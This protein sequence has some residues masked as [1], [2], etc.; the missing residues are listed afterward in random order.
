MLAPRLTLIALALIAVP[1]AALAE[2]PILVLEFSGEPPATAA[3]LTTSMAEAVRASGSEVNEASREDVVTLAGCAEASDDCLRQA[4]GMLEV[5]AAVTGEVHASG[6]GVSV[7]L[8]AISAEGEPRT[9]T[10]VLSG[11]SPDEQARQ[12]RPQ[13]EAFWKNEPAPAE[14]AP[15]PAAPAEPAAGADLSKGTGA[16]FSASRVEPYAWAIAGT[17]AGLIAVGS[18]L[19]VA[20]QNKQ[21]E[22]DDAPTDTVEDL[23]HLADLESSGRR[24]ARWGNV[25]VLVGGAAA[26]AGGFLIYRQGRAS[27]EESSDGPQISVA[28][29]AGD[30]GVGAAILFRGGF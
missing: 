29:S 27:G 18:I 17:G 4:L 16:S 21:G 7:E 24:Y 1:R 13:A 10:V 6:G 2:Q 26:I 11:A 28:P 22:V 15:E 23:D 5:Q 8:R 9:R 3:A 20:A 19:L 14:A 30:G 12:F 25:C